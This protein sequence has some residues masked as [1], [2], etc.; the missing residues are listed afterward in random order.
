MTLEEKL[1]EQIETESQDGVRVVLLRLKRVRNPDAVCLRLLD[2][3]LER[4]GQRRI[5]VLLCGVRPDI[6]EAFAK[7]GIEARLGSHRIFPEKSQIWSATME[8]AHCA[9]GLLQGD[10]C[11]S[12]PHRLTGMAPSSDWTYMI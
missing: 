4:M 12:C 7:V 2:E 1:L 8:A 3:F 9:Y 6:A 5:P 10:V 11:V